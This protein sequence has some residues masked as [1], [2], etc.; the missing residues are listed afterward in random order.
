MAQYEVRVKYF[1]IAD[2]LV[3][4]DTADEAVRKVKNW[5][6]VDTYEVKTSDMEAIGE[7]KLVD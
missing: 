5:N 7:P 2:A 6:I 3:E 1:V 4:A